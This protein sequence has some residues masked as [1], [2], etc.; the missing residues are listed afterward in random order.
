MTDG[1]WEESAQAGRRSVRPDPRQALEEPAQR[2][3]HAVFA[4][5]ASRGAQRVAVRWRGR[6]WSYGELE[7]R[8]RELAGCV[9]RKGLRRGDVVG[10]VGP[11]CFG[12][13][14]ALV[15]VLRSG[16][17]MAPID[18]R[19]PALR[20][21]VMLRESG[22]KAVIRS[23]ER[24]AGEGMP[25]I[26]ADAESGRCPEA[27]D[28]DA[29]SLPELAGD[30]AAYVFFTSGT[31]GA[32]KAVLGCHKG[33]AHFIHWQR[34][35]F[36]VGGD[37]RV[38]QVTALSFDPVLR[39]IFLPLASGAAL[40]LPEEWE[41]LDGARLAAWLEREEISLL[42][43][44]PSPAQAWL[45]EIGKP[46]RLPKLRYVFFA[47]ESLS[48]A[49]V[50]RWRAAFPGTYQVVNLYGPTE[51][52]MVKCYYRV[53]EE[54][55]PGVQPVGHALPQAQALVLDAGLGLCGDGE[56]GEIVI[57]T[58]F[59]TLGYLNAPEENRRRFVK[60]PFRE[61]KRDLLYRTG[62]RGRRRGDGALELLGRLNDE[63]KVAGVLVNPVEVSA[64]LSGHPGVRN[65][66]A[67][68]REDGRGGARL[69]A[70]VV[71]G[72]SVAASKAELRR[73]LSERLP[74]AAAPAE[75]V[76]MERMPL[77]P[78]GKID[79]RALPAPGERERQFGD[80]QDGPRDATERALQ[81]IWGEVLAV[82]GVGIYEDFFEL[83]GHSLAATRVISRVHKLFGVGLRVR[84]LFETPTIAGLAGRIGGADGAGLGRGLDGELDFG[85]L[86]GIEVEGGGGAFEGGDP[87][88]VLEHGFELEGAAEGLGEGVDEIVAGGDGG[89]GEAAVDGD[90]GGAEVGAGEAGEVGGDEDGEALGGGGEAGGEA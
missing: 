58:P 44:G 90:G 61:D 80:G 62:D 24:K 60:N 47:G 31:T 1:R 59:R 8:S 69:I 12:T 20:Q 89:E 48:S 33:L 43:A 54:P 17:V 77:L 79:R 25:V 53:P 15:G 88:G 39:E 74:A 5:W 45:A 72:G 11:P 27:E 70:Y 75:F 38:A 23:G 40:C 57:R 19:L 41:R 46:V 81:E 16:A 29:S 83:G 36:G 4:E 85:E 34:E 13:I 49:L 67:V 22:A 9:A 51:T 42:H 52:T 68:A 71:R 18:A 37:D 30:D 10:V 35:T 14:A 6:S 76:F 82:E 2:L 73:Y 32:P 66:A 7:R 28:T 3:V 64:V 56:A 26:A 50:E 65:C 55:E 63:V 86:A 78:N 21:E 87:G 84:D